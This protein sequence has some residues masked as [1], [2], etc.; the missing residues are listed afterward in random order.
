MPNLR[1]YSNITESQV[2]QG[3]HP[4]NISVW[5]ATI[6]TH[7]RAG[8]FAEIEKRSVE[9]EQSG[10]W[11]K[12]SLQLLA[13]QGVLKGLT[14]HLR[15]GEGWKGAQQL[16]VYFLL[17][18]SCM[19]TAFVLTQWHAAVRRLEVHASDAF[20]EVWGSGLVSGKV[21]TTVGISHL[22]TSRQHL[23]TPP[24]LATLVDSHFQLTGYCPWVTG[25]AHADF[26]VVG[27]PTDQGGQIL[28][29]VATHQAGVVAGPGIPLMGLSAS[30]TDRVDFQNVE[31]RQ[32]NLLA[33][34][35][36]QVLKIG[37][38]GPGGL[39][40]SVLALGLASRAIDYLQEQ[41][42]Q[43][44][45]F[46][47]PAAE[48]QQDL[49]RLVAAMLELEG[50]EARI[51]NSPLSLDALRQQAN[52][53]ALRATQAAMAAAKGAGYVEQH[54]VGRWCR[55]ALFFLVWSCPQAVVRSQVC[56]LAGLH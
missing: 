26:I 14:S 37:S 12:T 24:L 42:Q 46:A 10:A 40:T 2:L 29:I 48:L 31:I 35:I 47:E 54:P 21:W 4:L 27:A 52:S 51:S 15:G 41:A 55:E 22:T 13:D 50:G 17:A 38:G 18:K 16:P 9:V 43:R 56:E 5:L 19:T 3:D 28:G 7:L 8:C 1:T 45:D 49:E 30:C 11:P 20:W 23:Q 44:A 6:P 32:E 25:G 33:G 34:P 36:D 39:H 53:L